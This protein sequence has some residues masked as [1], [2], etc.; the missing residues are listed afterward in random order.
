MF[1]PP[2]NT[3]THT[4]IP[5]L[6][7]LL[8]SLC[9]FA[10]THAEYVGRV[11]R[12]HQICREG[13]AVALLPLASLL[14]SFLKSYFMVPSIRSLGSPQLPSPDAGLSPSV[15]TP[16]GHGERRHVTH[17]STARNNKHTY[18]LC[19]VRGLDLAVCRAPQSALATPSNLWH[20]LGG[21]THT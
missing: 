21:H 3:H 14:R 15:G 8:F 19:S 4:L 1:V 20:V 10:H 17:T 7:P 16:T 18:Y 11:R 12:G 9:T 2:A 6:F 5:C 13:L